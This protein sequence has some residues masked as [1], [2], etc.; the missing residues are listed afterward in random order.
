MAGKRRKYSD[1]FK[2]EAV[3]LLLS[4]GRGMAETAGNIGISLYTLSRWKNEFM[5][6]IQR[7]EHEAEDPAA[8]LRRLEKENRKM[9]G[10]IA[11]LKQERDILK[12]AMGIV[13]KQ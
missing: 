9:A 11:L 4:S 12:K 8:R 6:K 3:N 5:D 13:S 7:N 2:K 10:E 1:E